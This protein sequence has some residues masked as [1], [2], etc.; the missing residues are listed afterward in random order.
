MRRSVGLFWTSWVFGIAFT[1]LFACAG[2]A[3]AAERVRLT[4]AFWGDASEVSDIWTPIKEAFERSH[5]GLE[6]ELMYTPEGFAEKIATMA[7]AGEGPDI[8][9]AT[10]LQAVEFWNLGLLTDLTPIMERDPQFQREDY[11]PA[12]V[13]GYRLGGVQMGF[14]THFQVIGIWYHTDLLGEAGL[15]E[16]PNEWSWDE[17]RTYAQRLTRRAPDGSTA[18]WGT[19][20][21]WSMNH[22]MPWIFS[23]G[24]DIVDDFENPTRSRISAPETL[25]AFEFWHELITVDGAAPTSGDDT[26]FFE[27]RAGMYPYV[28]VAQRLHARASFHYNVAPLPAGRAG[29]VNAVLP[30]GIVMG[31]TDHPDEAWTAIKFISRSARI[32][33]NAIPAHVGTIRQGEWP[34]VPVPEGFR[35]DV[36]LDSALSARSGVIKHLKS[37]QINSLVQQMRQG[38]I[39]NESIRLI[40]ERVSPLID[41]LLSE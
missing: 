23:A 6:L 3:S 14:P 31:R 5:P 36:W 8:W 16:P 33:G 35:S 12:A 17:F 19:T 24:G 25:D 2:M 15:P 9:M 21:P 39:G 7:A 11:F 20:T 13:A 4:V 27:G 34:V 29:S 30:S 18:Q 10:P 32:A 40:A 26:P 28:A 1:L 37:G 41:A 22:W 38:I